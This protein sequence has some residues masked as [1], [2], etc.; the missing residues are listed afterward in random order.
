MEL[1]APPNRAVACVSHPA[2]RPKKPVLHKEKF[3]ASAGCVLLLVFGDWTSRRGPGKRQK[4]AS[5][6]T[7]LPVPRPMQNHLAGSKQGLFP[8][9]PCCDGV[10]PTPRKKPKRGW[11]CDD[12]NKQTLPKQKAAAR[13]TTAIIIILA[14]RATCPP[15][16][17]LS[18]L[19]MALPPRSNFLRPWKDKGPVQSAIRSRDH[20]SLPARLRL[21]D[22]PRTHTAHTDTEP[23]PSA[24]SPPPHPSPKTGT[25]TFSFCPRIKRRAQARPMK[26]AASAAALLCALSVVEGF[27]GRAPPSSGAPK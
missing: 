9:L 25:V 5:T 27:L 20:P 17:P 6:T 12:K 19:G 14:V 26:T 11:C 7:L 22:S 2:A 1:R 23:T 4:Q 24:S 10:Q 8:S 16:L 21:T 18:A 15:P 13:T 3:H